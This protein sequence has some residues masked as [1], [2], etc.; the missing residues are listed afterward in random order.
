LKN[1]P[2]S[3]TKS[4]AEGLRKRLVLRFRTCG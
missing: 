4:D 1:D 2:T 3:I